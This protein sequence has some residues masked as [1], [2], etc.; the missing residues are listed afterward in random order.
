MVI[1]NQVISRIFIDI[2]LLIQITLSRPYS[3][4]PGQVGRY[5][6]QVCGG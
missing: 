5:T 3:C 6:L 1:G 4:V 2:S